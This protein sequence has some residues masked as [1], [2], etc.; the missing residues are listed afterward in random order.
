MSSDVG[1]LIPTDKF[2]AS[3]KHRRKEK[4][5]K[6]RREGEGERI[7]E[8]RENKREEKR[9]EKKIMKERKII[10][11]K[12]DTILSWLSMFMKCSLPKSQRTVFVGSLM[13]TIHAQL[14]DAQ[15]FGHPRPGY[16]RADT[17]A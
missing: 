10:S 13:V 7:K 12:D 5:K 9:Q 17:A 16:L 15:Y 11:R 3:L 14:L 8:K 6:K 1:Q 4:R 2:E